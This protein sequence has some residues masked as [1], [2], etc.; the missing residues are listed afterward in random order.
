MRHGHMLN[1]KLLFSLLRYAISKLRTWAERCSFEFD[2]GD[3]SPPFVHFNSFANDTF[4]FA[5]FSPD[6]KT[7]LD[8]L[9]PLKLH[10][11]KRRDDNTSAATTVFDYC[12]RSRYQVR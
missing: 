4:I 9:I 3:G 8:K 12:D 6:V 2:L 11:E 10:A 5:R 1:Q 7:F